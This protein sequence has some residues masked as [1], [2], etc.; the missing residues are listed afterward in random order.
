MSDNDNKYD[1]A[2]LDDLMAA[3][4]HDFQMVEILGKEI[5]LQPVTTTQ[6]VRLARRFPALVELF[7]AG[8]NEA[9][10]FVKAGPEA[11]AAWVA[12]ATRREG[13]KKFEEAF[14]AQPDKL[15]RPLFI[16]SLRVTFGGDLEG[17]FTGLV[18]D[19]IDAGILK[20]K[21]PETKAEAAPVP[22]AA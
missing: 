7:E 13:N 2:A 10:I 11:V 19:L 1:F 16:Q 9:A 20:R 8:A 5:P 17:F 6:I 21:A 15:T 22:E 4:D 14:T 18:N 3:T 12:C